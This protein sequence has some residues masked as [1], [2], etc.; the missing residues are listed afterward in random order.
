M[1]F[2][3]R[4]MTRDDAPVGKGLCD[5]RLRVDGEVEVSV[6]GDM[7]IVRTISG[8][9]A[10]DDGSRCSAPLPDRDIAGFHFE[11]LDR[12]G[13]TRLVEEPSG[14]NGFAAVVSIRDS[15]KG[16]GRYHFRLSWTMSA[17]DSARLPSGGADDSGRPP[18][19]A[20]FSWNNTL[21]LRGAGRGTA[22]TNGSGETALGEARVE[23]DRSGKVVAWFRT[24]GRGRPLTF[25]GELLA[26]E[27][28]RWKADVMSE[29]RRLRGPMWITVDDKQNV[30]FITLDATD[31]QDRLK[32]SWERR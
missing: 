28:G 19:G 16:E 4:H 25:T 18:T 32:L 31:G 1:R 13:Q 14:R 2:Q 30:R 7:A 17:R 8:R 3:I 6:R 23:I 12:P 26:S 20:G 10:R 15:S 22:S 24:A 21:A 27:G 29:D 11:S 5:I 9:D